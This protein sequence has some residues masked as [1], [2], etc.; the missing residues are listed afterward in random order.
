[1]SLP[2]NVL[3]RLQGRA[4]QA[5]QIVAQLRAQLQVL[6][7]NAGAYACIAEEKKLSD[8]NAVLKQEIQSLKTRLVKA[9]IKNGVP[10]VSLPTGT[11]A[12]TAPAAAAVEQK[13]VEQSQGPN[14]KEQ[15]AAKKADKK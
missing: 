9:E 1:M 10:Q 12:A 4:A 5:D 8:E 6:K 11:P 7:N 15:K 13:P 14:K 2:A 3:Q